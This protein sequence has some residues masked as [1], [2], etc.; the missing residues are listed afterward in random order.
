MRFVII[1]GG[2][3]GNAGRHVR[4]PARRRG[5]ADRAGHRRRGRQPLGLHP[6]QGDDRHRRRHGLPRPGGRAWAYRRRAAELDLEGLRQR[7]GTITRAAGGV[8]RRHPAR[9]S[10][11]SSSRGAAR[12][13]GPHEVVAETADGRRRFDADAVLLCH[14]QPAPYPR[15][16]RAR[17]RPGA[18]HPRRLPAEGAARRTSSSSAPASPASSSCTCSRRSAPQVTLIVSRQQVL[19]RKDP[20]VAAVLEDDFLRRGVRLLKGARAV[21]IDRTADGVV[22]RCDDG[23]VGRRLPR[24]AGHRLDP[25]LRGARPGIGRSRGRPGRLRA[26]QP[27]L[28]DER[29]PHL[30]GRRPVREAAA[31]VGGV[32]AGPQDRR[33]RRRWPHRGPPAPELRQGRVGHLHRARD[34]RRRS[35][36]GRRLRRGPQDPGDQGPVRGQ[37]Q[38]AHRQRPPR[39]SSRSSPTRP[40]ASC[41]AARSSASTPPS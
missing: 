30:R 2:P 14:R 35:G 28:P 11:S 29:A 24:P 18:R 5:H 20:E 12:L 7:I 13:D 9:A 10:T 22:V 1:G 4:R 15:L 38:G 26:D 16:G 37:R 34:R 41:S 32:D 3:A 40:P 33:A 31:V 39:A 21:G 23:R 27:P 8:D 36:R 25:E 17:R 6:V 19:P